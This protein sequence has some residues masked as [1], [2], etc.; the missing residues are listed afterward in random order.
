MSFSYPTVV[1]VVNPKN[2]RTFGKTKAYVKLLLDG[3]TRQTG[4]VT[5]DL[6]EENCISWN[7]LLSFEIEPQSIKDLPTMNV[8]IEVLDK[9]MIGSDTKLGFSS[10]NMKGYQIGEEVQDTVVDLDSGGKVNLKVKVEKRV[11]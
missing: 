3:R 10:F 8:G 6:K 2:R 4:A 7:Q 11:R 1:S 9:A 5:V